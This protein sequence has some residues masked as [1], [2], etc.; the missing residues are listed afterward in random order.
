[1][2]GAQPGGGGGGGPR[3][4]S[5]WAA[6]WDGVYRWASTRDLDRVDVSVLAA[7][8]LLYGLGLGLLPS[9]LNRSYAFEVLFDGAMLGVPFRLWWAGAYTASGVLLTLV[10]WRPSSWPL[11]HAAWGV[12]VPLVVMWTAGLGVVLPSGRGNLLG[13][14][15][16]GAI[17]L[18]HLTTAVRMWK[19]TS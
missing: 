2:T 9:S 18:W 4:R 13:V 7:L 14:L 10:C 17:L 19:R 5:P 8:H 15:V 11:Q 3:G 6:L 1:V 16:F 12:A